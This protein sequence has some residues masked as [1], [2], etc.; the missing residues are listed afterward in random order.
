ML[1]VYVK[2]GI[3]KRFQAFDL[4]NC[5]HVKR[6]IYATIYRDDEIEQAKQSL[7]RLCN[8]NKKIGL[9]IQLR[10]DS[11]KKVMWESA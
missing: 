2:F 8:D 1:A 7:Q 3:E 5:V 11:D 9:K 6:L 10:R 4:E